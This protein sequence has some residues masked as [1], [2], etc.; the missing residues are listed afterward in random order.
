VTEF[1]VLRNSVLYIKTELLSKDLY[2]QKMNMEAN[3]VSSKSGNVSKTLKL[4]R[5]PV[6]IVAMGEQ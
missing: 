1:R 3:Q 6:T 5:V 2:F 4:R